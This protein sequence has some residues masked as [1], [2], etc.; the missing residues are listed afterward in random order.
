MK[1]VPLLL[2]FS[3]V[4]GTCLQTVYGAA[5]PQEWKRLGESLQGRLHP[6]IPLSAPC[7]SVVNGRNV[8]RSESACREV[9][10]GYTKPDFRFTAA[11]ARMNPQWETCMSTSEGCLLDSLNPNNSAAWAGRDCKQGSVP[12]YFIEVNDPRDVQKAFEFAKKTGTYLSIK[13]SGHDYKGRSSMPGSLSLWTAKLR[14]MSYSKT[15]TPEGGNKA[16]AAVTIG[17]GAITEDI[18]KFADENNVTFIGGYA[19]TISASGGWVQGG[20]HSVLSP[21][22]GLGVDR[23]LQFKIV[24]PDG[25]YRTANQFKN[26]DLYWALRGGGGGTFGV[27]L[28]STMS[29]EPAMSIRVASISVPSNTENAQRFLS[30]TINETYKWNQEGWGGHMTSVSLINVNP[31]LTLKEARESVKTITDFALANNGTS[32]VEDLPSWQAF[33]Q[34]YVLSAQAVVGQPIILG[35]RLMPTELLKNDSGKNQVLNFIY[36][37]LTKYRTEPYIILGAPTLYNYTEGTTSVTPAWRTASFQLGGSVKYPWNSTVSDIKRIYRE[38]TERV[39]LSRVIAPNSGAYTNEGDLYEP[40]HEKAF[41]GDNYPKLLKIKKK[42][43]PEGL[44]DCWH[45][46]GSRG[47]TDPRFSCYLTLL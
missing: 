23:V 11:S 43:D 45:C 12:P 35:T 32:V 10:Q 40:D 30:L 8:Q 19:Q 24:T 44:L 5:S 16:Y 3:A 6:A 20:G 22:Y 2:G 47:P 18:Y 13:A 33:F 25:E 39:Q 4:L 7:F 34:K 17:A 15:F 46:V 38:V 37:A 1:I 36:T 42:Y 31:R 29:V 14:S 21:V 41:W 26:Q 28:E 9:Q 27:V